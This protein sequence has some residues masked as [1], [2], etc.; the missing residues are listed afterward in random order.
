MENYSLDKLTERNWKEI[1]RV[2]WRIREVVDFQGFVLNFSIFQ[3]LKLN[4]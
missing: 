3:T 2:S 4:I 1:A